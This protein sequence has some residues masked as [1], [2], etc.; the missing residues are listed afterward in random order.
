MVVVVGDVTFIV[1][2]E[3]YVEVEVKVSISSWA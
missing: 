1:P 2:V 3:V